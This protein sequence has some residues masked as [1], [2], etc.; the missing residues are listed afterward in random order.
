MCS[1]IHLQRKHL[2]YYLV[3]NTTL[4]LQETNYLAYYSV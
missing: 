3:N 1:K 4:L 2:A